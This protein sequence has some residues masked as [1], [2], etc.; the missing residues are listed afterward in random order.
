MSEKNN[1][2]LRFDNVSFDYNDGANIILN[3]ASFSVRENTKITIMGQNGAGKSTIF[4]LITGELKPKSGKINIVNGN[5]VAIARQVIPKEQFL[6]TVREF[7]EQVFDEKDYQ[8]DMKINNILKE[9]NLKTNLDKKIKDFSGGQQA[10]LLLAQALIQE[11]DILLLDEPTNNLDKDG[12]GDL[13]GFL[14]TYLKTVI[15]IS[16]DADFLNM[17]TDGVLYLNKNDNTVEQYWGDYYTVLE[18]IKNQIEK[19]KSQNA[20]A[21]KKM[22][23]AKEKIN[24][25][26][27]KGGKMRKIAKKMKEE[28]EEV[29]D[30]KVIVRKDD[31]TIPNFE[32]PF[33]NYNGPIVQIKN[34]TIVNK[35]GELQTNKVKIQLKKKEK[36]L[37]KGPNGIGKSTL[38]KRMVNGK[39]NDA[40]ITSD[41]K[42]GYYSQDFDALDMSMSVWDSLH[43]MSNEVTNQEVYDTA[44]RF[45]LAKLIKSKVGALS[46]GQKGLL[47][48]ARFIIQRPDLLIM[49]EPSNH[50][51][52]RHL[53]V[54]ADALNNYKGAMI[55]ISHDEEFLSNIKDVDELDLSSFL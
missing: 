48:Y 13:I 11:P 34:I 6:Y 45:M 47:C 41:V 55:M 12:I 8:L 43:E 54:I 19:E 52:F 31:K 7:F 44:G 28:I 9:V 1:A 23:D 17:F 27:N 39:D 53:P 35:E 32:I 20:R 21:E 51:N 40:K 33:D 2:I 5:S 36:L 15:V 25:F 29:E 22:K 16:H 3:E 50:I 26:A 38:L 24:Y 18:E 42:I 46:E 4:K 30:E 37:I 49:D 14:L 10:R